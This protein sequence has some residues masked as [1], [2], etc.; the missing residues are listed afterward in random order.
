MIVKNGD[1]VKL[2]DGRLVL[3][4]DAASQNL[5][6]YRWYASDDI[7]INAEL[8]VET[9]FVGTSNGKTIVS[10]MSEVVSVLSNTVI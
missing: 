10:D 8:P 4:T 6:D 7:T 5:D 3:V 9:I 2:R 1:N